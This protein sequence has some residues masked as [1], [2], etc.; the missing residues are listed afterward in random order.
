M[1]LE[2]DG[3]VTMR[4]DI[5]PGIRV[6]VVA[7]GKR[8]R[9]VSGNELLGD[10][11]LSDIGIA[12][13]NDGFNIRAEGE[14]FV[15][16]TDDDVAL[17][18]EI[19]LSAATPRLARMMA[20]RHNPEERP[21]DELPV[22][23]RSNLPAVG[24]AVGGAMI[25]LGGTFLNIQDSRQPPALAGDP[26]A[27]EFWLAFVVGGVLMIGSAYLMSKGAKVARIVASALLV[28]M[29][30]MFGILVSN[31]NAASSELAAYVVIAGGIVVGVAVLFSG[32]LGSSDE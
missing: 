17:A 22:P 3:N 30:V 9:I 26:S 25:V 8:I 1:A 23:E 5:G 29:V 6:Q 27:V 24:F 21:P 20:T 31:S 13:L 16:H 2:L 11:V 32:S 18:D 4:G 14:E 10:W 28:A 12:A 7:D 15:L 19:G